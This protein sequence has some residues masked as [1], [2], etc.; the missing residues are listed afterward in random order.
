MYYQ[1]GIRSLNP[2]LL[3]FQGPTFIM[4]VYIEPLSIIRVAGGFL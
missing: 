3:W 1:C 4:I 2:S